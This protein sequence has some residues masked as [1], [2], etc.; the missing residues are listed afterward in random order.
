VLLGIT[1]KQFS[2]A[3]A[4]AFTVAA[5]ALTLLAMI[6]WG[7]TSLAGLFQPPSLIDIPLALL[8]SLLGCAMGWCIALAFYYKRTPVIIALFAASIVAMNFCTNVLG[9]QQQIDPI[10]PVLPNALAVAIV[11]GLA[12][13][14]LVICTAAINH[15]TRNIPLD[16]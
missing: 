4:L 14:L 12:V 10:I 3:L 16:L 5:A 2:L 11:A 8:C 13:L 6:L 1:R 15:F 9:F 7:L